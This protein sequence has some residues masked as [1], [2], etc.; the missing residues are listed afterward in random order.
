MLKLK[1]IKRGVKLAEKLYKN[2]YSEKARATVYLEARRIEYDFYDGGGVEVRINWGQEDSDYNHGEAIVCLP[3][4]IKTAGQIA[5]YIV[6][7][8]IAKE[9]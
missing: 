4:Y 7:Y 6:G 9:F 3:S 5:W 2:E 1:V 8:V